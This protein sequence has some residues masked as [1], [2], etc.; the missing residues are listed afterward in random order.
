MDLTRLFPQES[1]IWE[2]CFQMGDDHFL[3]QT[4]RLTDI[5]LRTFEIDGKLLSIFE[6]LKRLFATNTARLTR[7]LGRIH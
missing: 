6:E 3:D 7:D 2:K 1:I 4:I 5:V